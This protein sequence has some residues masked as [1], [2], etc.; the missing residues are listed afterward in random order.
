MA[1]YVIFLTTFIYV[2]SK[3]CS[4]FCFILFC[5]IEISQTIIIHVKVLVSSESS[6][7]VWVHQLGLRLFWVMMWKLL[8]IEPF[9]QWKWHKIENYIGNLGHLWCYSKAFNK[10]D[11]IEF[12]SQFSKPRCGR[13]WCWNEFY[14]WNFKKI[15][16][17]GFG[18]KIQ[19][20]PQ[21]VH[22]AKFRTFHCENVKNK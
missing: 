19:L 17:I 18:R 10:W 7:W 12:I 11:L 21:C 6:P 20:S 16:K 3:V 13:Y 5:H 2:Q 14:C 15:I 1:N 4:L 9:C 8:I 22:I